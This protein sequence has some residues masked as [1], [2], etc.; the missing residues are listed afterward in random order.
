MNPSSPSGLIARSLLRSIQGTKRRVCVTTLDGE[1]A[2]GYVEEA[3]VFVF[4]V[5]S[6]QGNRVFAYDDVKE[7]SD[8]IFPL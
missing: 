4:L 5:I 6:E 1:L 2:T 3:G 7:V 8:L